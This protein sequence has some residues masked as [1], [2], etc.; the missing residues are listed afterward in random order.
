MVNAVLPYAKKLFSLTL[1]FNAILTL[2]YAFQILMGY[3][4]SYPHWR[5]FPPI[6]FDGS[7][8]WAIV[9]VA[10]I[11]FFPAV[12]TGQTKCGRLWFHHYVYGFI[13]AIIA[14]VYLWLFTPYPLLDI[15]IKD[16][17]NAYVNAGRFFI[18]AGLTLV[19]DDLPDVTGILKRFLSYLKLKA[20]QGRKVLHVAQF[21]LGFVPLYFF[22]GV[23]IHIL[24]Y[25]YDFTLANSILLGTLAVT[26][27]TA[28]ASVKRKIWLNI[29]P[30]DRETSVKPKC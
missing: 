13:L 14:V 7:T 26:S 18:L 28:F 5:P 23:V 6:I 1:L 12:S 16:I 8:F 25:P 3:Y 22:V 10:L 9:P 17:T 11:N 30:D 29:K 15:F 20:Y 24:S 19:I 2:E 21:V 4:T 27:L